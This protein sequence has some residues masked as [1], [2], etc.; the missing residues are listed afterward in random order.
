MHSLN[1]SVHMMAGV[2]LDFDL[3]FIIQLGLVLILMVVL[4]KFVFNTYLE[5]IDERERKTGQTRAQAEQLSRDAEAMFS[6]YE[7]AISRARADALQS[8]QSLRVEG[9][10]VR[11]K[12]LADARSHAQAKLDDAQ[13]TLQAD[14][15]SARAHIEEQVS[16]LSGL[17]VAKVIG[18]QG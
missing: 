5:T 17:V 13:G 11:E 18:R 15:D 14:L 2:N 3:T 7:E 16:E 8:R 12:A 4:K 6:R 10:Q 1:Q 9:I